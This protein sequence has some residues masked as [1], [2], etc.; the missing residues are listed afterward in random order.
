MNVGQT[1]LSSGDHECPC[2]KCLSFRILCKELLFYPNG[3][4][5]GR[6]RSLLNVK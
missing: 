5:K 3:G 6:S 1:G 4:A 2:I